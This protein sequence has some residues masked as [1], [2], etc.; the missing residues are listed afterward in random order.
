MGERNVIYFEK[1]Y[2]KGN[3]SSYKGG[4]QPRASSKENC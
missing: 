4:D 2:D 3:G 1:M